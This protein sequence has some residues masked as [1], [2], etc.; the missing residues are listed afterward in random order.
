MHDL[1]VF[2]KRMDI[3]CYVSFKIIKTHFNGKFIIIMN[4]KKFVSFAPLMR[5]VNDKVHICSFIRSFIVSHVIHVMP[6]NLLFVCAHKLLIF[7]FIMAE[8]L[9]LFFFCFSQQYLSLTNVCVCV[10]TSPV[11]INLK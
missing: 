1:L 2:I 5:I 8:V 9:I 4:V 10:H 11:N 3:R 6:L 7:G